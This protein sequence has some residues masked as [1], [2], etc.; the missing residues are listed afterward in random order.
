MTYNYHYYYNEFITNYNKNFTIVII[1]FFNN[2]SFD[3]VVPVKFNRIRNV[4]RLTFFFATE[5]RPLLS[6]IESQRE[7]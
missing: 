2:H 6:S 1:K 3:G 4:K 7:D 5:S